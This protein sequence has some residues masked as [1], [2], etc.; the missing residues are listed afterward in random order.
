MPVHERGYTHWNPSGLAADPPW[1]VIAR[2]GL[3]PALKKRRNLLLLFAALVPAIIKGVI[4]FIKARAGEI[5]E[6][7]VGSDWTSLTPAGFMAFL[8]WWP[9][10][11]G[12]LITLVLGPA[13]IASDKQ[14]NGLSLY[15][16]RPIG[17]FDY[18]G[19]KVLVVLVGYLSVTLVPSLLL[20][21]FGYLV[22]PTAVGLQLLLLTPLRLVVMCTFIGLGLSLVIL[23]FSAMA[24]RTVLVV[25][26]WSILCIGGGAVSSIG[27]A[28]GLDS[29]AYLDFLGH[30]Y[31]AAALVMSAPAR[32]EVEPAVSLMICLAIMAAAVTVLRRRIRPVEVVV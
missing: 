3:V 15:F 10:L 32:I 2:R 25:V 8:D 21:V 30:W 29:F 9:G 31:N 27:D 12:F 26:W 28:V 19:G 20:C 18:L 1:L 24:T 4:I 23:S 7:A 17:V 16:S 5:L 14:E 13:L 11:F 6:L 22:D